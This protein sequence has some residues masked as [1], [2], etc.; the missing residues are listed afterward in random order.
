MSKAYDRVEW[1]FLEAM[2]CKMG[3]SDIW[4]HGL[5]RCVRTVSYGVMVNGIVSESFTPSRG[6]RQG[7]SL[8]P[9]IFL[10]CGEG[11]SSLIRS[12]SVTGMLQGARIGRSAPLVSH[13]LFADDSLIFSN[14]TADSATYLKNLLSTYAGC[15]GQLVNYD[16]SHAFFSSNVT[17]QDRVEVCN[18]LQV[19]EECSPERYLGLPAVVGR[20][21]RRAFKYLLDQ[22]D[23]KTNGLGSRILSQGG[24]E[25][26]IKSILQSIPLFVMSCF[27]LSGVFCK[28]MEAKIARYWWQHSQLKK[29]VHWCT[30]A[31]LS[32]LK[33][34]DGLGFRDMG[35]FNI[36]LLAKQGW[37]L[38]QDPG[39]LVGRLLRAKYF[40][41]SS[42]LKFGLGSSQSLIWRSIWSARGLLEKR[43]RLVHW[44]RDISV[45]VERLLV[46]GAPSKK[47]G[48]CS[49]QSDLPGFRFNPS[50]GS[51]LEY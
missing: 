30:W 7:D 36:A 20:N 13:L 48:I 44:L 50:R 26:L 12:A 1:D 29:G 42:F 22:V 37:R 31:E 35:K 40:P 23:S 27:L 10:I 5:M 38:V 16:K 41:G 34:D 2:M 33:E 24:K 15:S 19:T 18:V 4:V 46:T 43:I 32:K 49:I 3:F 28:E 45:G 25:I 17:Q 8:S 47:S 21:K 11:L 6:L 51:S 39:S 9:Y 14:A